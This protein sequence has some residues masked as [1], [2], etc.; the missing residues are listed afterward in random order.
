LSY[1]TKRC[2][3][4]VR[5]L[6]FSSVLPVGLVSAGDTSKQLGLII[7]AKARPS[8]DRAE[9]HLERKWL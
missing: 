1:A 3:G 8:Y 9:L 6:P 2:R 5:A 4:G 7:W